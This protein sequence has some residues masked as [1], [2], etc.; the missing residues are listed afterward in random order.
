MNEFEEI[1]EKISAS[2]SI[3]IK[4][5]YIFGYFIRKF[6]EIAFPYLIFIINTVYFY[7]FGNRDIL[8]LISSSIFFIFS[9]AFYIVWVKIR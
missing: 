1:S 4:I 8:S 5:S 3:K 2:D 7:I 6:L 9:I